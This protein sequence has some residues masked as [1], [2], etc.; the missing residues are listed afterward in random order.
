MKIHEH[1][2]SPFSSNKYNLKNTIQIIQKLHL[3]PL[4]FP[5]SLQQVP[6][7]GGKDM[8]QIGEPPSIEYHSPI[9][10]KHDQDGQVFPQRSPTLF[11]NK[12]TQKIPFPSLYIHH[13]PYSPNQQLIQKNERETHQILRYFQIIYIYLSH[14]I[15]EIR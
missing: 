14:R 2:L 3:N 7:T 8:D 5:S 1:H 4:F 12:N 10:T 9:N 13:I 11:A 15:P 6:K